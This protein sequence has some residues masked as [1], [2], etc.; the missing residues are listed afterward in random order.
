MRV[1]RVVSQNICD[2]TLGKGPTHATSAIIVRVRRVVSQHIC[3]HTLGKGPTHAT[4]ARIV[5]VVRVISR[6][7][8]DEGTMEAGR[9]VMDDNVRVKIIAH[10]QEESVNGVLLSSLCVFS[11]T[12]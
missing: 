5:R 6:A 2:P 3:D 4:S 10:S 12:Y 9:Y 1:R 7:I 8:S 11:C